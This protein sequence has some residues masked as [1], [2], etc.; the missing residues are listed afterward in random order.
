MPLEQSLDQFAH[1]GAGTVLLL[2]VNGSV[3]SQKIGQFLGDGNQFL[4]LVKILDCLW[5]G[6]R[7]IERQLFRIQPQC[8]ALRICRRNILSQFQQFLDD[9][10]IGKHPIQIAVHGALD[11]LRKLLRF[12]QI[13][14][15]VDGNLFCDQLFQKLYR[16]IF[17]LHVCHFFQELRFK[18]RELR[19]HIRE[20]INYPLALDAVLQ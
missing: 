17:L 3:L 1:T 9:F 4:M 15:A 10:L 16:K 8:L 7:V 5:L 11:D 18:Q 6:E 19:L 12:D 14:P 2:P 13:C 20:K